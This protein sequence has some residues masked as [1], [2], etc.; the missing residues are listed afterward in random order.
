MHLQRQ[1]PWRI[2]LMPMLPFFCFPFPL[3]FPLACSMN[4]PSAA[5]LLQQIQQRNGWIWKSPHFHF[6]P[7]LLAFTT[8]AHPHWVSHPYPSWSTFHLNRQLKSDHKT[9]LFSLSSKL[10]HAPFPPQLIFSFCHNWQETAFPLPTT[11]VQSKAPVTPTL[12]VSSTSPWLVHTTASHFKK[13]Y[14]LR[15]AAS[16]VL[17]QLLLMRQALLL[18]GPFH[19]ITSSY[20][21]YSLTIQS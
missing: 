4:T 10:C 2:S 1:S 16:A 3:L 12:C 19:V 11:K 14:L 9:S 5:P 20:L 17:L 15:K 18:P 6:Q 8:S 13:I 21:V 7:A